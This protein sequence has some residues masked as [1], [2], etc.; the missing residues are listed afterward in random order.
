MNVCLPLLILLS[1]E[2]IHSAL[3]LVIEGVLIEVVP[4][5]FPLLIRF[6]NGR[7]VAHLDCFVGILNI[8]MNQVCGSRY[9]S[10]LASAML[11]VLASSLHFRLQYVFGIRIFNLLL[12]PGLQYLLVENVLSAMKFPWGHCV[13]R[14]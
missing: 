13:Q 14:C 2:S 8:V 7:G 5:Y 1:K 9:S 10:L 3:V 4:D 11:L 12:K 6:L